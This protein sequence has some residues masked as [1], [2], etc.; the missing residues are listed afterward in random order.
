MT[1][2]IRLEWQRCSDGYEF[3]YR[4]AENDDSLLRDNSTRLAAGT[5][6]KGGSFIIAKSERFE[7]YELRDMTDHVALEF[8]NIQTNIDK[9]LEF[10]AKWGIISDR[11]NERENETRVGSGFFGVV[12]GVRSVLSLIGEKKFSELKKSISNEGTGQF[13]M[14]IDL[15][16]QTGEPVRVLQAQGLLSFIHAQLLVLAT[17]VHSVGRCKQCESFFAAGPGT[18]KRATRQ[19]CS[20]KCRL[21]YNRDKSD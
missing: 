4:Q 8:A 5:S 10:T 15:D 19:Y 17:E 20:T 13:R 6:D 21:K 2:E 1:L 11:G 18:G 9:A 14:K 12:Y 7:P 3:E 16:E